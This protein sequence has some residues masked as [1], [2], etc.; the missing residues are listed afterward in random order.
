[1]SNK[2]HRLSDL[3]VDARRKLTTPLETT[4]MKIITVEDAVA[5]IASYCD[6]AISNDKIGFNAGH[7]KTGHQCTALYR[8]GLGWSSSQ[9]EMGLECLIT[10]ADQLQKHYDREGLN[11]K[12]VVLGLQNNPQFRYKEAFIGEGNY[13]PYVTY[14]VQTCSFSVQFPAAR[15][16]SKYDKIEIQREIQALLKNGRVNPFYNKDLD[17][18]SQN[19]AFYAWMDDTWD[20]GGKLRFNLKDNSHGFIDELKD[21][22]FEIDDRIYSI[23]RDA[24]RG[25]L[26]IEVNKT[27]NDEEKY[28][29]MGQ[30]LVASIK[31]FMFNDEFL[32]DKNLMLVDR[33]YFISPEWWKSRNSFVF[34]L[35]DVNFESLYN[36]CEMH[37]IGNRE[38]LI[39]AIQ[40]DDEWGKQKK[41]LRNDDLNYSLKLKFG[42]APKM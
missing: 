36:F 4:N 14:N 42:L 15:D 33:R 11:G 16:G 38:A 30:Y 22:G 25:Y 32:R 23:L 6:G 8:S 3:L 20:N 17:R 18:E 31:S 41:I 35:G 37:N 12:S 13:F 39:D 7:A 24:H 19:K 21:A 34:P 10:Y 5:A 28:P 26:K 40:N 9:R 29:R 2:Y 1:M 27:E